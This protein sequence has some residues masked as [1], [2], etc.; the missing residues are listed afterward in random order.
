M[1]YIA[2]DFGGSLVKGAVIKKRS[3]DNDV[4]HIV[5]RFSIPSRVASFD[6]WFALFDPVFVQLKQRYSV[7]GIA[8]S[9]CGAVDVEQGLVFGGSLLRYIIDVN[10]KVLFA[11]RYH[12]PVEVEN[13]ACCAALCE[14]R[15][16]QLPNSA[17][18]CLVVIGSGV[19]GAL[20]TDGKLVKGHNLYT[21]EFGYTIL[22]FENGIP[23]IVSDLASTRGLVKQAA[24][25]FALPKS[26]LD[27]KK[28]FERYHAGDEVAIDVVTKWIGHLAT[29]LFNLQYTVDP[30]V[31]VLGG[32]ISQQPAL[33]P[34]LNSELEKYQRA[35]P[36]C[37]IIPNLAAAKFGNDA[38]LIGAVEHFRRYH[39]AQR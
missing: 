26:K 2:L 34:L 8:I 10:V 35:M 25:A 28:V 4:P 32:A 18:F 31:I 14:Y 24:Q 17:D 39:M 29:A 27:G 9:A 6:D 1:A 22:G 36:Y 30:E 20:I 33:I 15:Y 37:H 21:G 19:G 11:Q 12:L 7:E 38:N 13:D 16:G 5:E 23:R 3:G